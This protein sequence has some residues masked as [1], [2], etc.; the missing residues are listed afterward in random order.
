MSAA[1]ARSTSCARCPALM[2][3]CSA[4][5]GLPMIR[6]STRCSTCAAARSALRNPKRSTAWPTPVAPAA[7][8]ASPPRRA[9]SPSL[10]L[11]R[12]EAVASESLV[13]PALAIGL[14]PWAQEARA[15][16]LREGPAL[17][18]L[19]GAN[20]VIFDARAQLRVRPRVL[21]QRRRGLGQVVEVEVALDELAGA[22][23]GQRQVH[24]LALFDVAQHEAPIGSILYWSFGWGSCSVQVPSLC[25]WAPPAHSRRRS[26]L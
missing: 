21:V 13:G 18:A 23:V 14:R 7:M 4:S 12:V 25:A 11:T 26:R 16:H 2:M 24:R 17:V 22:P 20:E 1:A 6:G 19:V 15:P 9:A 5:A 3:S 8:M 10:P